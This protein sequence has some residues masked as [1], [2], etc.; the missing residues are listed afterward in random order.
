M[1]TRLAPKGH[2]RSGVP[3]RSAINTD[4]DGRSPR[5]HPSAGIVVFGTLAFSGRGTKPEHYAMRC[6]GGQGAASR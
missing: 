3:P 2:P 1:L 4:G 5:E 6:P